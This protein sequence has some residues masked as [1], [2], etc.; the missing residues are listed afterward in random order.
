M[1]RNIYSWNDGTKDRKSDPMVLIR[2]FHEALSLHK[3]D[4]ATIR[5][6]LAAADMV[7]DDDESEQAQKD[8]LGGLK[9]NEDLAKIGYHVFSAAPLDDDGN[10]WT[11]KEAID[12]LGELFRWQTELEKKAPGSQTSPASSGQA[13]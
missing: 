10:G 11:E 8:T 9:A 3:I 13:A 4:Y 12:R 7:K 2:R 1:D 6:R 5:A